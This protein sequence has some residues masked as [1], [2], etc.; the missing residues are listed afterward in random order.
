MIMFRVP[1]QVSPSQ[2]AIIT[3]NHPGE[4]KMQ[5]EKESVP[6][7]KKKDGWMDAPVV[8]DADGQLWNGC[9]DEDVLLILLVGRCGCCES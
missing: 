2:N 1:T 3:E 7:Q 4:N 9:L 8:D 6:M 5:R